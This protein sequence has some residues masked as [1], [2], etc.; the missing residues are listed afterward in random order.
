MIERGGFAS[1]F[2]I[3][4][5][6]DEISLF[7]FDSFSGVGGPITP[8][9]L[10][11]LA[12]FNSQWINPATGPNSEADINTNNFRNKGAGE[13][14]ARPSLSSGRIPSAEDQSSRTQIKKCSG[15]PNCCGLKGFSL[16]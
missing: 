6:L 8:C 7:I 2:F 3:L 13:F 10:I 5:E 12:L 4:A 16:A 15:V 9:C 11:D 14:V 1:C